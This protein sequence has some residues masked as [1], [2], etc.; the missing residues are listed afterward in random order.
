MVDDKRNQ[1]IAA[2]LKRFAHFGIAKTSMSEIADDLS[3][4]KAN[5]YYYFPDKFS[6]IEA[7]VYRILEESELLVNQ[8]LAESLDTLGILLRMLDLKK[9]YLDKYY[10]L[11]IDLN[12]LNINDER[13]LAISKTLFEREVDTTSHIFQRGIDLGELVTF[14]VK[15]TS[16]LYV[17]IIR[18]LAMFCNNVIPH[19]IVSK[20]E[21]AEIIERQKQAAKIFINGVKKTE[22]VN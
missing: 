8:V 15:S 16:E 17:A 10:M 19:P 12:E 22:S 20:S 21:I 1:I 11:V 18:G 4:S 6:V 2:A 3:L 13:W 5:L 14:E 9:E 7:I